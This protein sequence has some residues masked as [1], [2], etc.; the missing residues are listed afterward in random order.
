MAVIRWNH[1]ERELFALA[2]LRERDKGEN[3]QVAWKLAQEVLPKDRR[4]TNASSGTVS[5]CINSVLTPHLERALKTLKKEQLKAEV[6]QA[7]APKSVPNLTP[8]LIEENRAPVAPLFSPLFATHQY[9]PLVPLDDLAQ[10]FADALAGTL[11]ARVMEALN[12]QLPATIKAMADAYKDSG[13]TAAHHGNGKQH[14]PRAI[15]AGLLPQQAGLIS[16]EFGSKLEIAFIEAD[17][18]RS[19]E[20]IDQLVKAGAPIYA[21]TNFI[22]HSLDDKLKKGRDY[23]R[24]SGG[25]SSLRDQLNSLHKS[26][27]H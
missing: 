20:R 2:Y 12:A 15:V 5:I 14:R 23:H 8:P 22:S 19:P 1:E 9:P 27:S 13:S 10:Q 3:Q 7:A 24:I 4:R 18:I 26:A 25:L 21:M 16:Q 17:E 11:C 6:K